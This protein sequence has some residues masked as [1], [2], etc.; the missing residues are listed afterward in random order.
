MAQEFQQVQKQAQSIVLAPQLRNSLKILQSP[1]MDLRTAILEE[2]QANPLLEELPIEAIS[3]EERLS[4]PEE[5]ET[6]EEAEELSFD[7]KDYSILERMSEDMREQFAQENSGQSFSTEDEARREHFFNSLTSP[8]SLQQHLIGQQKWPITDS[9]RE[10]LTFL[11]GSL[12]DSGFHSEPLPNT[13]LAS[14]LP[15]RDLQKASELLKTFDLRELVQKIC[16]TAF[17]TNW[18]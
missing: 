12:D 4:E 15:L 11:I 13:A 5:S 9:E 3:V 8:V 1:A 17:S 2:L 18:L 10:A 16:G 6:H 7:D 14:R